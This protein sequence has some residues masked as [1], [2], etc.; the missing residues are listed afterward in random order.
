M[1]D[2]SIKGG[3]LSAQGCVTGWVPHPFNPAASNCLKF[4]ILFLTTRANASFALKQ[5]QHW[6]GGGIY[7][8]VETGVGVLKSAKNIIAKNESDI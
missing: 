1:E 3:A 8:K 6:Q 2:E 5:E 4:S 7:L